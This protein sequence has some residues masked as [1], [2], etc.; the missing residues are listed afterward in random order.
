[1]GAIVGIDLGTSTSEVAV[2]KDGRPHI[3]R[4]VAGS[5]Q[6][7]LPSVVGVGSG[8]EVRIGEPAEAMAVA[9]PGFSVAEVKR[10]MGKA[11][12]IP[13]AGMEHSPQE[14]SAMIL[15][16]LKVEAEKYLGQPVTDAVITVPARFNELQRRATLDAGE[17]AGLRVRRLINEPTAAAI[18]YGLERPGADERIIVYDLGGGTLDVTLLELSEG[19]LDVLSSVGNDQ[20]GGKDLDDRLMSWIAAES[21]RLVDVDLEASVALRQRLKATAK[22]AKEDLSGCESVTISM[23]FVGLTPS[24]EP[25]N[26][27]FELSRVTFERLVEDL[28]LSTRILLDQALAVRGVSPSQVNTILLVGGSTRVPL[29]RKVVSDFFGGR[30]L[31]TELSPEEAVALGAAVVAGLEDHAIDPSRLVVTDVSSWTLGVE[32]VEQADGRPP[33]MDAFDPLIRRHQTIPRTAGKVYLTLHDGQTIIR[34]R[35]FQGEG[36]LVSQN[37]FVGEVSHEGITPGPAGQKVEIE[38]SYDLSETLHVRVRDIASG[39]QVEA[40]MHPT[41]ERLSPED[42]NAARARLEQRWQR[43]DPDR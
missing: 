15:R 16:H 7:V 2:L 24:R 39:R 35:V 27:E 29:V 22:K 13:M 10:D 40:R 1:M 12:R 34:V 37:V 42:M 14:I 38:F 30:A 43:G 31:R 33:I 5:R 19:V 4:E 26:L 17:L 36:A 3:I 21:R 32:V 25:I 28:V 8:G 20:L 18:A 41:K 11:I 23:P 9:R 6:G